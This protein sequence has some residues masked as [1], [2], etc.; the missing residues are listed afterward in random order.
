M[1]THYWIEGSKRNVEDYLKIR[2]TS[3]KE[4]YNITLI[5]YYIDAEGQELLYEVIDSLYKI[6]TI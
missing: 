4:I 5:P 6:M 2:S 1:E 3:L